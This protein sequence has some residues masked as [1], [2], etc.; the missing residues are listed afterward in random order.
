MKIILSRK[1]FDSGIGRVASPILPD[2][3]LL[4]LPIPEESSIRYRDLFCEGAEFEKL[5]EDLTSGKVR[6]SDCAHLDP[7]LDARSYPRQPGWRPLFGPSGPAMTH[8][9]NNGLGLGDLFLFFGWFRQTE[10]VNGTYRYVRGAPD[11]HVIFGWLQIGDITDGREARTAF[12][13]ATYHAHLDRS[14][15]EQVFIA[16][17]HLWLG[18]STRT[19]GGGVFG[20]YHDDLC[21]TDRGQNHRSLWRLPRSFYPAGEK[22]PLSYH[23]SMARWQMKDHCAI[24]QSAG[25]GQEFVLDAHEYPEAVEW[26]ERMIE[27]YASALRK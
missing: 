14:L 12:P 2:G 7:D 19:A 11:L 10:V 21:L 22:K 13:W 18:S 20:K 23:E 5:V 9:R 4:S 8:L 16:S 6:G 25:R 24:L 27:R 15:V 26:A 1:G 3:T 17:R